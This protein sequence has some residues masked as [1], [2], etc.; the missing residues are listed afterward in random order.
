MIG[1]TTPTT[2]T[3]PT[4]L[5]GRDRELARLRAA[6]TRVHAGEPVA[7]LVGGEAGV[8]KTRLV[9]AFLDH[10]AAGG[11]T[12]LTGH[13]L[14]LGEQGLPFAPFAEALR[15]VLRREGP[16]VFN[17]HLEEFA[18]LL[19]E[20]R[21]PGDPA[22][23]HPPTSVQ[24]DAPRGY[25][26][27]LLSDLLARLAGTRPL[28]L[29]VEDLHWAD[30]S[31]RDLIDF[32][33]RVARAARML[34]VLSYRS[35]E[36]HRGHPLRA[37]L[38]ELDRVRGVGRLELGRLDRE[39]TARMLME[40]LGTEPSPGAVDNIH[41]RAQGNPFF[42]E[43]LAACGDPATCGDMPG[44][45]RDLL[46]SRIDRLPEAAQRVL[47]VAA[48][49]GVRA[50]HELLVEVAGTDESELEEAIRTAVLGQLLIPDP[51]GGYE[52]RHA[53]VHEAVHDDLLP[54]ERVRLHAR[55]AAAI[56]A[57]PQLVA[58]GRAPAD[59]ARHWYVARDR[60]RALVSAHTAAEVAGQRYAYAEQSHLLG[61]VLDLWEQVPDAADRLG[62]D[63]LQ[64]LEEA[65]EAASAAGD[66]PRAMRLSRAAL[67]EI[68]SAA[69]PL[70]A[71]SLL[72]RRGWLL[73]M[74]GKSNG[75][76]EVREAY[77]LARSLD[78]P[79]WIGA[80][81][82]LAVQLSKDGDPLGQQIVRE[83]RDAAARVGDLALR[84][85]VEL[86]RLRSCPSEVPVETIIDDLR[87]VV[88]RARATEDTRSLVLARVSLSDR[89]FEV[90]DYASSQA[91]AA[92]G[93]TDAARFGISRSTGVF[94]ISNQA[95]ALLALGDWDEA[96]ALCAQTA[97]LDPPGTLSAHWLTLRA[98]LWL[99]RGHPGAT[100]LVDRALAYLA[101]PFLHQQ[102][103]L[104]LHALRIEAALA[105]GDRDQAVAAARTALAEPGLADH[106]RY[107]WQVLAPI[108]EALTTGVVPQ[109]T[110]ELAELAR[111]AEAV[112]IRSSTERAYAAQVVAITTPAVAI[113]GDLGSAL[114][115]TTV[116]QPAPAAAEAW[117]RAVE[118]WRVDG[119]PYE[120]GRALLRLAA[121]AA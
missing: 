68:D 117:G 90:G 24:A 91:T 38:G 118:A 1:P 39:G 21:G 4:P 34:L 28:V 116:T 36:L 96:D 26:F 58:A 40:V 75:L 85:V 99:A 59:I 92:R 14:D 121:A 65:V 79:Q 106:P 49:G 41:A 31:T 82:E 44:T 30:C 15:T 80:V 22:D 94:L 67:D 20:L 42:I 69:Q 47:R 108:A 57:R 16:G 56:E 95:E 76:A 102:Q 2:P 114:A 18:R 37:F 3:T 70:R 111:L 19:P 112:A 54:G 60:P 50:S 45:L 7:V 100:T 71:A 86:A 72:Q 13:C 104:P 5:V 107:A 32:L 52:F 35:D 46:L 98:R 6:L 78:D 23:P 103:S 48:A 62:M 73:R 17:G 105:A 113:S 64:L 119:Q 25:L 51:D 97:R 87:D 89:Q 53:L 115:A 33:M 83:A 110:A 29:A 43:E 93:Q 61:R 101:L 109:P 27:G 12:V 120:L 8:G 74:L 84:N 55:Y 63:H 9:G 11:A 66:Y 77:T 81:A 10:A 88:D